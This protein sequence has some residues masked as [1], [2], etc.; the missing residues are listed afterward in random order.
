MAELTPT[1]RPR[2]GQL[3]A[4]W[5]ITTAVVWSLVF[6]ALIAVWK[7]SRELGLATWWLGPLGQPRPFPVTM[8][9]FVA[10]VA[11]VVSVYNNVTWT[12]WAG[13]VAAAWLAAVG[14]VDLG[15]VTGLAIV[16]LVI[17]AAGLMASVASFAG[18]YRRAV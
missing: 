17:A 1:P 15:R 16:T 11:M 4:G 6:V 3:T 14:V 7:T 2:A 5:R 13:L 8:L 18:R 10:P 12:P 9:P